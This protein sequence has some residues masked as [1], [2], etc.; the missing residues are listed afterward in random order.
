M[1]Q[2][3][4]GPTVFIVGGRRRGRPPGPE[5]GSRIT[6]WVPAQIHDRL[7]ETARRKEVS[8]STLIRQLV[9]AGILVTR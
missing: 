1:E 4:E 8:V 9:S 6:A 2:P 7:I 3:Q 5:P